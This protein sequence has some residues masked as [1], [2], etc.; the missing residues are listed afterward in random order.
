MA[1]DPFESSRFQVVISGIAIG[2]FTEVT[3]LTSSTD[4]V[5]YREGTDNASA[6]KLPGR[7]RYENIVLKRG[8]T[9]DMELY[10]WHLKILN[11]EV[12]R[13]QFSVILLDASGSE[14]A[15]WNFKNAWPCR[16]GA[17]VLNAQTNEIAIETLE[18]AH[19]G[20]ERVK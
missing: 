9:S 4:V 8:M 17:P 20:M 13:R 18:L 2:D 15:R 3:G 14:L 1:T 5:E 19:E 10:N 6:R 12:D 16:Y 7:V 11:G